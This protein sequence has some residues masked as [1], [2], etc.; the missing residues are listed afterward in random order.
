MLRRLRQML[1]LPLRRRHMHILLKL[2]VKAGKTDIPNLPGNIVHRL[3]V[4]VNQMAGLLNTVMLQTFQRADSHHVFKQ[5]PQMAFA[6]TAVG[7]Q[8]PY[9]KSFLIMPIYKGKSIADIGIPI[10]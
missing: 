6:D 7:G 9:G 1:L 10:L 3:L 5:P 2:P 8:L 4:Q